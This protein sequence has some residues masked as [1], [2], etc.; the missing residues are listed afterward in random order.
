MK[1]LKSTYL[2]WLNTHK[3]IHDWRKSEIAKMRIKSSTVVGENFQNYLSELA[4]MHLK[5]STIVEVNF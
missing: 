1:L 3:I 4:K 2:K 5:S